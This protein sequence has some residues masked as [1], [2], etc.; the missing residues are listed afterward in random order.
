MA[1]DQPKLSEAQI[2]AAH[3]E[4]WG[5]DHTIAEI[6]P[7]YGVSKQT[8]Q[9]GFQRLDLPRKPARARPHMLAAPRNRGPV[10][11][12]EAM[13]AQTMREIAAY[14]RHRALRWNTP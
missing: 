12:I 14:N 8:L 9:R 3:A 2:R 1:V 10:E 7:R 11:E 4:Y 13:R 5:S 6:A